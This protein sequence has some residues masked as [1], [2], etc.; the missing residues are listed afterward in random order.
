M[1]E[2][3]RTVLISDVHVPSCRSQR[4]KCVSV[5]TTGCKKHRSSW[6][7][8]KDSASNLWCLSWSV[9]FLKKIYSILKKTLPHGGVR[10]NRSYKWW[11]CPLLQEP[12]CQVRQ[13]CHN[14]LQKVQKLVTHSK[15]SASNLW[16]LSWK[17]VILSKACVR[18]NCFSINKNICI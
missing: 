11:T 1:V 3:G 16:C 14:W 12:A 17:S 5:A 7:H 2:Y 13:R 6:R 15:D 9:V 8:S 4:V 18:A 10:S